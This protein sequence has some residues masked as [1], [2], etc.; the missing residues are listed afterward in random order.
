MV[1][2]LRTLSLVVAEPRC[3]ERR[4]LLPAVHTV[5]PFVA[6]VNPPGLEEDLS[7]EPDLDIRRVCS[8]QVPSSCAIQTKTRRPRFPEGNGVRTQNCTGWT[9]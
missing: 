4:Q 6:L 9:V 1:Q 2:P 7:F 5:W 3:S 8:R